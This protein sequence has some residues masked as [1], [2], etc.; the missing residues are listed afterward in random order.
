MAQSAGT[1]PIAGAIGTLNAA[2][3]RYNSIGSDNSLPPTFHKAGQKL[4]FVVQ[5]LQFVPYQQQIVHY[6]PIQTRTADHVDEIRRALGGIYKK[7]TQLEYMIKQVASVPEISRLVHYH[8]VV[9]QQGMEN[10][11]EKLVI[12]IVQDASALVENG[13]HVTALQGVAAELSALEPSVPDDLS[14]PKFYHTG[15]GAQINHTGLGTQYNSTGSG[16]QYQAGV[17]NFGRNSS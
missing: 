17:M 12:G 11:V 2:K 3:V 16:H 6:R 14:G 8:T 15:S 7:A 13:E 10:A 9:R 1:D 4:G 5:S